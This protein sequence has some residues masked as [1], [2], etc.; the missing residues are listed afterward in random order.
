LIDPEEKRNEIPRKNLQ[1]PME[2]A[3]FYI[4]SVVSQ[5]WRKFLLFRHCANL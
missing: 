3:S 4:T 5:K 2:A 1:I